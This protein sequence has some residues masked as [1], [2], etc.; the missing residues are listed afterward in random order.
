MN[1]E[2]EGRDDNHQWL[3]IKGGGS[4]RQRRKEWFQN[5]GGIEMRERGNMEKAQRKLCI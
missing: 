1:I 5:G 4:G 3:L 2:Q